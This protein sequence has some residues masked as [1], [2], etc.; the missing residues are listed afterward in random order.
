M[1]EALA[2]AV[3]PDSSGGNQASA[4]PAGTRISTR[5]LTV[6]F[7]KMN[8][9]PWSPIT[10]TAGKKAERTVAHIGTWLFLVLDNPILVQYYNIIT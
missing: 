3:S 6:G 2:V 8:E 5:E 7:L 1:K 4:H 9:S 10:Q